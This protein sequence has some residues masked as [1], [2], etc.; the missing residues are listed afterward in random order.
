[1][2]G[3]AEAAV[4]VDP[5]R[6]QRVGKYELLTRLTVGGMAELFL[7]FTRGPGG[8]EKHVVIKRILP[9]AAKNEDFVR[10]FLD[11][12]RLTAA[13]SH[14]NIVQ[15]YD[16]QEDQEGLYV[17]MEYISGANLNEV[18]NACVAQ[19]AVLPLGFS[20]AVV[21][22]SAMAL[23]YAHTYRTPSG[24]EISVIHRDV[25][26]KNIMVAF[27]GQV[28]LLD[29]GIAKA[30]GTLSRT[31][32]GTVKGTAGYM[33]P[34]QARGESIDP[35]SDVF[36]LG[37]VMWEMVTGQRLFAAESEL[38]ELMLII[39]GEIHR[40]SEIESSIPEVVSD[41]VMKALARD[42]AKRWDSA[43][44][45]ARAIETTCSEWLFDQDH[46]SSF[47]KERFPERI[48]DTTSGRIPRSM[49]P[50]RRPRQ[51]LGNEEITR[52][53]SPLAQHHHRQKNKASAARG[54][55]Q[56]VPMGTSK[57]DTSKE[58]PETHESS[59]SLKPEARRGIQTQS[60]IGTVFAIS[61]LAVALLFAW[62]MSSEEMISFSRSA[63]VVPAEPEHPKEPVNAKTPASKRTRE[64]EPGQ[65]PGDGARPSTDSAN[66]GVLKPGS[67]TSRSGPNPLTDSKVE[68]AVFTMALLPEGSVYFGTQLVARGSWLVF[69]LP[70]G[71][72]SLFVVGEDG[73]RR[74]LAVTVQRGKN[75]P[76]RVRVED[77]PIYQGILPE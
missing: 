7:G 65:Q 15:V 77:I 20:L 51:L 70:I 63:D 38:K 31:T 37:V 49:L 27:D 55:R 21:H 45:L 68:K 19:Q 22:D 10:M 46:R 2:R 54:A 64:A 67:W 32:T 25:A 33:S 61:I 24:E 3:E 66:E 9:D 39:E 30:K 18:F 6:G 58:L 35:R 4:P 36:S 72:Q 12:A 76:I 1:M 13:F 56:S 52:V 74:K 23:H 29:F 62:K 44:D 71:K 75:T 53:K 50:P 59:P 14:Q 47:M 5:L 16:L 57:R 41:V 73:V 11:E 43:K 8:F 42:R 26:Q 34:E 40:P 17:A 60:I 28:K 48:Q 69:K